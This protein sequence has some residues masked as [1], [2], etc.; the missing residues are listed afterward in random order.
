M[1][2]SRAAASSASRRA[3][4]RDREIEPLETVAKNDESPSSVEGLDDAAAAIWSRAV[5]ALVSHGATPAE[6]I[7]GANMIVQAY[8]RERGAAAERL[9]RASGVR[10]KGEG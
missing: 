7:D 6:A 2:R 9:L 4:N 3:N 10:T 5:D 8:R 1:E